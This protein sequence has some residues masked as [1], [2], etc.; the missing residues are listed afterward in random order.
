MDVTI[1]IPVFN[2]LHFTRQ[3]L[4][5]LNVAGCDDSMIVV[6]NNASTDGTAEFLA[7]R[8]RLRVIHNP[9]NR[10]CAAAWNQGFAAGKT[11]WTV[12]LNN[13]TLVPAGWLESLVDFAEKNGVDIAS[14]AMGEGDLDYDFADY[15]RV[16]VSRMRRVRRGG[17][18]SG[19]CFMVT[20]RVFETI[21]NFD[22]NFNKGG[23]EDMDFF[24]RAQKAGF[25]TAV[26]GCAYIH[27]FGSV[28]QKAL[29]AER[30]ST[31]AETVGYFRQKWNIGWTQRRWMQIRRK[32][33]GNWRKI[34]ERLRYGHTLVEL[35]TAGKIYYCYH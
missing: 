17:A 22:E 1:V 7:A 23:N 21:G 6:V 18:A 13:D 12:F 26:T 14:P 2:Q 31:R 10:A 33:A 24:W 8:P 20:R 27:H 11:K 28:T 5:S 34:S 19:V 16:F 30:G 4:E 15:S 32:T 35:R 25:K 29:K 9:E 3:C